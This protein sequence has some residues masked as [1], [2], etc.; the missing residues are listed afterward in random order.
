MGVR[1]KLLAIRQL[2]QVLSGFRKLREVS[3]PGNGW[4][5]TIRKT[6]GM[7]AKQLG[8]RAGMSQAGIAQIEKS[9]AEGKATLAT[10]NKMAAALGCKFVYAVVPN[11]T[12]H[13]F[14]ERQA[15]E[16]AA[17]RVRS[18]SHSMSLESQAAT[19]E[20]TELQIKLLMDE[21]LATLPRHIWNQDDD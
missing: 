8:R 9:E 21:I 18:A 6:L 15:R 10:M 16:V 5:Q 14:I 20:Q 17:R 19:E 13:D 4:V 2:D 7:S 12:L 11:S 1:A 3:R